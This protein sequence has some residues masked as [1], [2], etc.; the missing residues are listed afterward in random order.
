MKIKHTFSTKIAAQYYL[1]ERGWVRLSRSNDVFSHPQYPGHRRQIDINIIQK[2]GE[3]IYRIVSYSVPVAQPSSSSVADKRSTY[4]TAD[5][6]CS[7][8]QGQDAPI[9]SLTAHELEALKAEYRML[10]GVRAEELPKFHEVLAL[11]SGHALLQ[12]LYGGIKYVSR[13]AFSE[14][15]KRRLDIDY[16]RFEE[17]QRGLYE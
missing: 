7:L 9:D 11:C 6:L 3:G 12:L 4:A 17:S 16:G 15:R 8:V 1:E 5:N 14:A 10:R 13:L 2:H